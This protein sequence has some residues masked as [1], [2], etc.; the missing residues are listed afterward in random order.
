MKRN[1][2]W[3]INLDPTKGAEIK[4][5]RPVIIVNDDGYGKLP[6]KIVVP[7]TEWKDRYQVAEWMVK[8]SPDD[9]NNLSK[10]SAADC[11]QVRSVSQERFINK[12]GMLVDAEDKKAQVWLS[13]YI[14]AKT[15]ASKGHLKMMCATG[16]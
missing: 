5:P 13:H 16:R 10:V 11:F 7:L 8:I 15:C 14:C 9:Q 6:L 3:Q 2:I 12:I 4:K 1:E